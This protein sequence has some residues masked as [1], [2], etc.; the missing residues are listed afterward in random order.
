MA[1]R[2][3][4]RDKMTLRLPPAFMSSKPGALVE[5]A[6]SP[7]TW[8]IQQMTIEG[9]A[10]VAELRPVWKAPAS[11]V[12]DPGRI[13]PPSDLMVDGLVLA[14]V[15]LPDL[16]GDAG[17]NPT[18]YLAASSTTPAWKRLPTEIAGDQFSLGASTARRKSAMGFTDTVLGNGAV[19][20]IDTINAVEVTLVDQD[21]W[22]TSCDDDALAGGVNLALVG[23]EL[24]QF[25]EA[26]ALGAGRFRL[27][28]LSRGRFATGWAMGAHT[29]GDLFVMIDP[30]SIQRIPLPAS[31]RD[32]VVTASCHATDPMVSTTCLVDGRSVRT[33]LFVDGDQVVG[34]RAAGISDPSGG[35]TVDAEARSAV[36][37][38][39]GTLRQHGLIE[40]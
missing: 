27:T 4:Q 33:G 3:A 37:Q 38:I 19:G 11:L 8:Q 17:L 26:E 2:W 21:Q 15:E 25:A 12:A 30:L 16:T 36:E 18:V 40:T 23:D 28:R 29:A 20:T 13:V 7:T 24:L 32:A 6:G 22:L 34:G 35:V 1:R 10:V 9:M 31:A 14:L 39:L 5:V